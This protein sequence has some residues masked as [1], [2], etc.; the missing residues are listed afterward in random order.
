MTPQKV[1]E[2]IVI[3]CFER[4]FS[5]QNSV[6]R[7]K[8]NIL[9]PRKFFPPKLWAGYPTGTSG[10]RRPSLLVCAMEHAVAFRSECCTGGELMR[11][12]FLFIHPQR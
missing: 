10:L 12:L 5:K 4:R 1:L 9:A 11:E 7:L 3:L 6:I 8:S 2:N